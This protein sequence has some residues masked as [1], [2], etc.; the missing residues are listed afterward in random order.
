MYGTKSRGNIPVSGSIDSFSTALSKS[1]LELDLVTWLP[2][3]EVF[4]ETDRFP[5]E[6]GI[7]KTFFKRHFI[8]E[9][10]N[11]REWQSKISCKFFEDFWILVFSKFQSL[12]WPVGEVKLSQYVDVSSKLMKN[13][14][15]LGRNGKRL[16]Y[17]LAIL[18]PLHR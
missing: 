16:N 1:S 15:I 17:L 3:G 7:T 2:E 13:N 6:K 14:I 12:L 11:Y 8:F 5:K 18:W 10:K 9:A 4:T